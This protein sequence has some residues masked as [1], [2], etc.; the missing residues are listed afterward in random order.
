VSYPGSSILAHQ[1]KADTIVLTFPALFCALPCRLFRGNL[2][3]E[4]PVPTALLELCPIEHRKEQEFALMRYTAVTC[5][6]DDFAVSLL[7]SR[8]TRSRK[9]DDLMGFLAWFGAD[10]FVFWDGFACWNA[11]LAR[12]VYVETETAV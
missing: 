3:L 2:V 9:Q 10:V 1:E 8:P 11:R 4:C 5:G 7:V 6:P 12:E